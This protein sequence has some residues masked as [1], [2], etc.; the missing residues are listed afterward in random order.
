MLGLDALELDGDLLTGDD[1]GAEVDVTETTTSDLT[2][3]AV[4]VSYTEILFKRTKK[5]AIS[6]YR[7]RRHNTCCSEQKRARLGLSHGVGLA[8]CLP[9]RQ[10]A[11]QD[12]RLCSFEPGPTYRG[13]W[14]CWMCPLEGEEREYKPEGWISTWKRVDS[15]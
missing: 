4:L 15:P 5:L 14:R 6:P 11:R 2:A 1:V 9:K 13:G 12:N 8:E 3:D 10:G 7:V